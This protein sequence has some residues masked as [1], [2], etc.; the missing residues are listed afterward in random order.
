MPSAR[1]TGS[2]HTKLAVPLTNWPQAGT[3]TTLNPLT[4]SVKW[5][6]DTCSGDFTELPEGHWH[7]VQ[8]SAFCPMESCASAV[9]HCSSRAVPRTARSAHDNRPAQG[10]LTGLAKTW[11]AHEA[12]PDLLVLRIPQPCNSNTECSYILKLPHWLDAGWIH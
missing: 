2:L 1:W 8:A 9:W 10:F 5:G 4:L 7:N 6:N 12:L 3:R 11:S